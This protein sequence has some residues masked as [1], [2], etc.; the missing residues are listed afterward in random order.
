MAI[1]EFFIIYFINYS[2]PVVGFEPTTISLT[3]SRST[4]ELHR[5]IPI[6]KKK[7]GKCKKKIKLKLR[8]LRPL[9]TDRVSLKMTTVLLSFYFYCHPERL[10]TDR[11]EAKDLSAFS[12]N[13]PSLLWM[14][15]F[16]LRPQNDRG[17]FAVDGILR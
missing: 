13:W 12:N 14:G 10:P 2:A 4:V 1:A 7:N 6:L 11:W 5:N 3:G 15:F 9:P 17:G 8:I 16:G